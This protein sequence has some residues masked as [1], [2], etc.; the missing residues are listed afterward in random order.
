VDTVVD[1]VDTVGFG[2]FRV[3]SADEGSGQG[4]YVLFRLFY[5]LR[6]NL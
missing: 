5:I 4:L 1:T 3:R 2:G 6:E